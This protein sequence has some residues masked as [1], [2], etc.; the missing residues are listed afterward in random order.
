MSAMEVV[1]LSTYSIIVAIAEE[2]RL[3]PIFAAYILIHPLS[4]LKES[5]YFHVSIAISPIHFYQF[6]A[7]GEEGMDERNQMLAEQ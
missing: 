2:K 4:F 7:D 1:E 6:M 5:H 3:Q